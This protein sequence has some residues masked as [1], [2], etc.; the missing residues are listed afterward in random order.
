MSK[1]FNV[2]MII[3]IAVLLSLPSMGMALKA[4]DAG[5]RARPQ[6]DPNLEFRT[7]DASK[8][9]L[10]M[11]NFGFFGNQD[12]PRY[13]SCEFPGG[14]HVEYLFQGAVWVGAIVNNEAFVSCGAEGWAGDE[15][16][17][18][19]STADDGIQTRSIRDNDPGAVSEQD[20]LCQYTDELTPLSD[21][22][23]DPLG[24]KIDQR[25]Y[26][27]SYSYAEDFIVIDYTVTNIR[28]DGVTMQDMYVG[29]YIDADV[30]HT[31]AAGAQYAQDDITGFR[32]LSINPVTNDTFR[33]EAAWIADND[34]DFSVAN[35]APG[36]S[37]TRVVY[38][39]M[40]ELSFNW[41]ISDEDA[42][43]DYGPSWVGEFPFGAWQ[44]PIGTPDNDEQKY[45]LMSN[46]SR[47]DNN[48]LRFDYDQE[49]ADQSLTGWVMP[50]SS[51]ANDIGV[52]EDTRYLFSFGPV[53]SYVDGTWQL[54]PGDSAKLTIGY[55]CAEDF[56]RP[57]QEEGEHDFN[58]FDLN[59]RWVK[60]VYDN[61]GRDTY[62][63]DSDGDGVFDSGDGFSGEDTGCDGIPNNGDPPSSEYPVNC[64]EG[65]NLVQDCEDELFPT[66]IG[67]DGMQYDRVGYDN[68]KL[69][70]GDGIPDF[71]GPPPP[72]SP[73][74]AISQYE[75]NGEL[76]V[77][78]RWTNSS[79]NS[80][81]VFATSDA[82]RNKKGITDSD[83]EFFQ[84]YPSLKGNPTDFEGFR[85]YKSSTQIVDDFER[86][87][88]YDLIDR[89]FAYDVLNPPVDPQ[90]DE[91]YLGSDIGFDTQIVNGDTIFTSIG[92]SIFIYN[93]GPV[94]ANWPLY[95]AVTAFDHGI[96]A[97]DVPSLE[98]SPTAN[99]ELIWPSPDPGYLPENAEP[100]VIP[101]PYRID[102]DYT[103][104]ST[105][106]RWD[107]WDNS[108]FSEHTR[109][110]DFVN[111]PEQCTI[112]IY[113]LAGDLVET[114]RHPSVAGERSSRESW[115][116]ITRNGQSISTGIYLFSV[117]N[118][119][120]GDA[121][122]SKFVVIR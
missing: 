120:N 3:M 27:W 106:Y 39:P 105:R 9:W 50:P 82:L 83:H 16:F 38:P 45:Y 24:L 11:T 95:F 37:G 68:D 90:A 91:Y 112:R 22:N 101:N 51:T 86:L 59:A 29:L 92:D 66:L 8:I 109:R 28:T 118:T 15:E 5:Q 103:F 48:E 76:W 44:E 107:D 93:Y 26:A 79:F 87:A 49:E 108:G 46:G 42:T 110:I 40:D 94:A 61:P 64:C 74:I 102:T 77:R 41:W 96:P 75:R 60:D 23:H 19:G 85:I 53:G 62:N 36:V 70:L 89:D 58:D 21:P 31:S 119:E 34:G 115:D 72:L 81:D 52:G 116:M 33:V 7:H 14:S 57:G 10:T 78:I 4:K 88:E 100:M 1:K 12:D 104:N 80:T 56:H 122:V 121:T 71:D 114:I 69:E 55:F 65:D 84:L 113:T 98:S 97:A 73:D 63:I 111:L 13:V 67:S 17:F 20:F 32:E 99:M 54:A 47:Q 43:R 117:E 6:A 25:S 35:P 30:G 18:P 2:F